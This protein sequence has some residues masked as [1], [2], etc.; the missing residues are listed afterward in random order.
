MSVVNVW[1]QLCDSEAIKCI[2]RKSGVYELAN[3]YRTVIYI[4]H[5]KGGNLQRRIQD[6]TRKYANECIRRNAVYFRYA[7]MR[8]YA[9]GERTLFREY[10]AEHNNKI[11]P[12]NSRDPSLSHQQ[13]LK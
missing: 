1:H 3:K 13:P 5:A 6:H 9:T 10:K 12:C 2:P 4:G 7:V 8:A 11:P